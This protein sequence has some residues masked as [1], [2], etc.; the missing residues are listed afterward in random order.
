MR[1]GDPPLI[2]RDR[3]LAFAARALQNRGNIVIGSPGG[4]GRSRFLDALL[5]RSAQRHRVFSIAPRGRHLILRDYQRSRELPLDDA[6]ALSGALAAQGAARDRGGVLL[7]IDDAHLIAREALGT[8]IEESTAAARPV[9]VATAPLDSPSPTDAAAPAQLVELSASD[10]TTRIDLR[11]L[12]YS[13][14]AE[15][16]ASLLPGTTAQ[17]AWLQAVHRL[18]GGCPALVVELVN[19]AQLR[20]RGDALLPLDLD[21]ELPP[22]R[23]LA[24]VR[25]QLDPLDDTQRAALAAL[26]SLGTVPVRHLHFLLGAVDLM[27]LQDGGLLG[28]ACDPGDVCAGEVAAFA[29]RSCVDPALF[30]REAAKLAAALLEAF[31]TDTL[32]EA[33]I[34]FAARH[35]RSLAGAEHTAE[36]SAALRR[37]RSEAALLLSE[38]HNPRRAVVL[39]EQVLEDGPDFTASVGLAQAR[40]AAHDEQAAAGI[41]EGVRVPENLHE[42]RILMEA[43]LRLSVWH[44]GDLEE[45]HRMLDAATSWF[46]DD[47]QWPAVVEFA[48]AAALLHGRR[49]GSAPSTQGLDAASG[50]TSPLEANHLLVT[51]HALLCAIGG[52][53]ARALELMRAMEHRLDIELEPKVSI[54]FLRAWTTLMVGG[55][56]VARLAAA[57]RQRRQQASA[58]DHPD[59]VAILSVLEGSLLLERGDPDEALVVLNATRDGLPGLV[60]AWLDLTRARAHLARGDTVAA[61]RMLARGAEGPCG[62]MSMHYGL[63]RDRVHAEFDLAE[64]R[65][66]QARERACDTVARAAEAL[67]PLT[68]DLLRIA[69][70]AGEP[71]QR[72]LEAARGLQERFDLPSLRQLVDDLEHGDGAP[73]SAAFATRAERLL[74]RLTV[75]EQQIVDMVAAGAG[76]QEIAAALHLSVRTVESHLHHVRTKL[77][78][79]GRDGLRDLTP[80]RAMAADPAPH[81]PTD[82]P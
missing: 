43:W 23:V 73:A 28:G 53:T 72:V 1:H 12:S 40:T 44:R 36:H 15:L 24:I 26:G 30:E 5:D 8:I 61:G 48:R 9:V 74:D 57:T 71:A 81:E 35:H 29:A 6:D 47:P 59:R 20:G 51:A 13:D 65:R 42:A 49:P 39:A 62:W 32:S 19:D 34:V 55:G 27:A 58:R 22:R 4:F 54:F 52:R 67:P 68:T 38:S 64:G 37:I 79:R 80:S 56:D 3:E 75:R 33:E 50:I 14:T 66:T 70:Q 10:R 45:F 7:G 18:S 31:R 46:A 69:H 41:L 76:N 17:E 11:P 63:V 16:A 82:T 21:A 2:G 25:S 60:A 77:G 78:L